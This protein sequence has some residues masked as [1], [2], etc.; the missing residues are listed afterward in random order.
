M[1]SYSS[2]YSCLTFLCKSSRVH[3]RQAADIMD[4]ERVLQYYGVTLSM[5]R[6]SKKTYLQRL[7]SAVSMGKEIVEKVGKRDKKATLE[8]QQFVAYLYQ[9]AGV[10]YER[11]NRL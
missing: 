4:P 10:S 8:L 11:W 9:T 3:A 5:K 1:T 2:K 7:Q 6:V